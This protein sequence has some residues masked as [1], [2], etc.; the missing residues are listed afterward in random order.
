[1]ISSRLPA[2]RSPNATALAVE[3][4]RQRGIEPIDLTES[5]PTRA[6][7]VY[8][9]DLLLPLAERGALEYDPH[10]LGLLT[11]REA[12]SRE[13]GRRGLQVAPDRI[14]LTA[15]TSE[16]YSFLFKLLCDA[17]DAVLV[18]RP[19]YPLFE[20][21]T[22]LESVTA[23]PY[24][25][26]YHGTWRIDM[27]SVRNARRERT[28]AVLVV[29][30]NNPTGSFLHGDDLVQLAELCAE[31][32]IALI[33]DEVFADYPL[34]AAPHAC[35]VLSQGDAVTC[36]LG[37]L[38]KSA[39]LPQLKLGWIAFNGPSTKLTGVLSAYEIV[40]DAYLSVSTPIQTAASV[41]FE[42]GTEI[43]AQIQKR[44]ESNLL[45]LRQQAA[46]FPAATVLTCE[47]G[48]SA[49]VQLP[50]LRSEEA[51]VLELLNEDHVLVHPGYFFDF[52]REAFVVVSLIVE[53]S[54]FMRGLARLLARANSSAQV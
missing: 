21:L 12:V 22:N 24:N 11:A 36:S 10:P 42:K 2:D 53:P 20:H 13:F 5:N 7:F 30:P 15:S 44:I 51:L 17:G 14:G 4:L 33:G 43:R 26:E 34:D 1:M 40:A 49:V 19:S 37:G 31:S 18:P 46:R 47:G 25:L 38:S 16:A 39:G 35:S 8:P 9:G 32:D 23:A 52:P 50:T 54:I 6:G 28:K 27:D 41:L 3:S 45:T 29:S 48:W